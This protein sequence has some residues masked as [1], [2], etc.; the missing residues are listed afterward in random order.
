[1]HLHCP[2]HRARPPEAPSGRSFGSRLG[3][4]EVDP[5]SPS[6]PGKQAPIRALW[7]LLAAVL[8]PLLPFAVIGE[9]PGERWLQTAEDDALRFG[10]T[11]AGLLGLCAGHALGWMTHHAHAPG[12]VRDPRGS[13]PRPGYSRNSSCARAARQTAR[14]GNVHAAVEDAGGAPRAKPHCGSG[15]SQSTVVVQS[16]RTMISF[17]AKT[18]PSRYASTTR[19][20][21]VMFTIYAPNPE[22]MVG[23]AGSNLGRFG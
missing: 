12:L 18:L 1:M 13:L 15:Y 7:V 22:G 10:A 8:V 17:V 20:P 2:P 23:E 11:G 9:L 14:V 6:M 5:D 16:A 21:G 4:V 19:S 3:R